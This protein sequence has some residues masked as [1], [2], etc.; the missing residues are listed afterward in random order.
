MDLA[1]AA[2]VANPTSAGMM[3]GLTQMMGANG[4]A[5]PEGT[6]RKAMSGLLH[7]QAAVLSFGDA[8]GVLSLGCWMAVGLAFFARPGSAMARSDDVGTH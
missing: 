6:A 2:N 3:D 1:S 5:D 4:L 8:F 7:R